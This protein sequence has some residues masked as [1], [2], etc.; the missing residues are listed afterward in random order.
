MYANEARKAEHLGLR[1]IQRIYWFLML[2]KCYRGAFSGDHGYAR[3]ESR[4]ETTEKVWEYA[5]RA[6]LLAQAEH[7]QAQ[8]WRRGEEKGGETE[9]EGSENK[10]RA[11]EQHGLHA[12]HPGMGKIVGPS[13]DWILKAFCLSE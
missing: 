11:V 3:A 7:E 12:G 1:I 2:P 13:G 4:H 6:C 9:D 10:R 5:V 8:R